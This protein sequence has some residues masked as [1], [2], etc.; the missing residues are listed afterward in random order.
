MTIDSKYYCNQKFWW[1][2]VDIEKRQ[3]LS[4]CSATPDRIDI[5]WLDQNP[6]K[7]FNTP[8][9][10]LERQNMLSGIPVDSCRPNCWEAEENN[11]ISRRLAMHGDLL[12][13][14]NIDALPEVLHIIVGSDCNMTCVYCCKQY[15]SQWKQDIIQ[16]GNYQVSTSD[17]RFQL[18]KQDQILLRVGQKDILNT[19]FNKSLDKELTQLS[20]N[21]PL[22][23]VQINGGET[24]LY[25]NL[26]TLVSSIPDLPIKIWSGLGVDT[27][28][29]GRE[30]DK[31]SA[32]NNVTIVIS[33]ETTGN[34]YEFTRYGNTWERFQT[35]LKQI[36]DRN[37]P[38]QF[39]ATVTNLTVFGIQEFVDFAGLAHINFEPCT[40]PYF[41]GINILNSKSRQ[42]V[43]EIVQHLLT[44]K[45]PT[46]EQRLDLKSYLLEFSKRRNIALT[47]FP[48][49]FVRWINE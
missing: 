29:F 15:S 13:H 10:Q 14:G 46:E 20:N 11:I 5:K 26:A 47:C 34:L 12:T 28:R 17:D 8:K 30:L 16:N 41:L 27:K 18:T 42:Q 49:S 40:D 36:Q 38:Y 2:S 22:K 25:S 1:L 21:S 31:L 4:C 19:E 32:F 9:L 43:P 24:F 3:T 35:N 39:N 44:D 45:M 37:I 23:E 6:G 33:A 7:L 48:E